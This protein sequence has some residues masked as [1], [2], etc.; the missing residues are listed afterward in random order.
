MHAHSLDTL[1]AHLK[2]RVQH[3]DAFAHKYGHK[4]A[5]FLDELPALFQLFR[6]VPF[7][8][9]VPIDARRLSS[10]VALYI[11]E[12]QDFLADK[13]ETE[14]GLVDDLWVAYRALPLLVKKAGGPALARHWR[15][16]T[17]F[18]ELQGLAANASVLEEKVPSKVLESAHKY[19][20]IEA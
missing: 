12:H 15:G 16:A 4:A 3:K 10:S 6:R 11:A 7:D 1:A 5:A 8:L 13:S 18:D 14:P 19:L 17:S 20:D 2:D 9:D